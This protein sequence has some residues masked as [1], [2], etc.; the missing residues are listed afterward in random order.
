MF[1]LSQKNCPNT[2][3]TCTSYGDFSVTR[4][5]FQK[6]IEMIL[7]TFRTVVCVTILLLIFAEGGISESLTIPDK[8]RQEAQRL[9][10]QVVQEYKK[11]VALDDPDAQWWYN[12][13][14]PFG[15]IAYL[16]APAFPQAIIEFKEL[17]RLK[18][19]I[20]VAQQGLKLAQL[21]QKKQ[22]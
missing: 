18:P 10:H 13:A 16:N 19:H 11:R 15:K 4:V 17:I 20:F 7:Y 9:Y 2:T 22:D 1:G 5:F 6:Q 3:N 21:I 12:L 14:K 8:N